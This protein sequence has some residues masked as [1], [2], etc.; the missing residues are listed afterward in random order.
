MEKNGRRWRHGP[1]GGSPMVVH[2]PKP[3]ICQ[4]SITNPESFADQ[5]KGPP[6]FLSVLGCKPSTFFVGPAGPKYLFPGRG[7]WA[8]ASEN[9]NGLMD[10][11]RVVGYVNQEKWQQ[12]AQ[13]NKQQLDLTIPYIT[14]KWLKTSWKLTDGFAKWPSFGKWEFLPLVSFQRWYLSIKV[15]VSTDDY[16]SFKT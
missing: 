1:F 6:Q 15:Q 12:K 3:V 11:V 4:R 8:M 14:P 5:K 10:A 9:T 13:K 2:P 16:E 7:I